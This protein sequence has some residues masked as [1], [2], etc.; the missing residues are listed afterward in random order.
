MTGKLTRLK[1]EY[2]KLAG[3]YKLPEYRILNEEFDIESVA[4][5]CRKYCSWK[6]YNRGR[7]VFANYGE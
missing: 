7:E 5:K 1:E 3:K 4:E 2:G 6:C